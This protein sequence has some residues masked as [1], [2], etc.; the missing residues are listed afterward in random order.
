MEV[1]GRLHAP[2]SLPLGKAHRQALNMGLNG[3]HS[4]Y[5]RFIWK[6]S[7]SLPRIEFK[8]VSRHLKLSNKFNFYPYQFNVISALS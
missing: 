2:T 8:S 7:L 3:V 5:G 4:Q 6:K 1:D